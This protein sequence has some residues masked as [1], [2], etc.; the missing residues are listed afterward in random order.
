MAA[1]DLA[2]C[3][4]G[5]FSVVAD[6]TDRAA[7]AAAVAEVVERCGRL[8]VV[9]ANAGVAPVQGTLR[10][11]DSAEYDRVIAVNQVGVFNTVRPAIEP[12]IATKGHIRP[13]TGPA[14]ASPTSGSSR[15][16]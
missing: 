14:R 5:A 8:D 9:V 13:P 12:V 4:D 2:E 11:M 3:A 10:T 15:R 7:M 6:V 16:R 1:V